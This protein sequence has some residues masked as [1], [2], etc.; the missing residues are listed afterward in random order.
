M[1]YHSEREFK[2][3][4]YEAVLTRRMSLVGPGFLV[5]YIYG[6]IYDPEIGPYHPRWQRDINHEAQR[7]FTQPMELEFAHLARLRAGYLY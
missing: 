1:V 5:L 2:G 7:T 3:T 6:R 4:P